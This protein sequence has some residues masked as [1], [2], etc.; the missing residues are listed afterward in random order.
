MDKNYF[1]GKM[2]DRMNALLA[3]RGF[4]IR[5]LLKAFLFPILEWLF[6]INILEGALEKC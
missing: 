2:G 1:K 6:G 5:K 3:G 4:N